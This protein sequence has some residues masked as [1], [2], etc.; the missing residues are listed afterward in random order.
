LFPDPQRF[1]PDRYLDTVTNDLTA[2]EC[3]NV[4]DPRQRDHWGFGAGRR[5]CAGYNL[6]ENSLFILTARLLWAFD[7]KA[8]IDTATGKPLQYDLWDFPATNM[9]GPNP[10][11]AE[12]KIR[13]AERKEHVLAGLE[14]FKTDFR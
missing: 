1:Y 3:I 14:M 6:A 11:R 8:P 5:V 10:F 13:D 7:V 9:F 4:Q 2:G 12:F